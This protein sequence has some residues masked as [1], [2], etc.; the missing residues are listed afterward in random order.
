MR[1]PSIKSLASLRLQR[2][3]IAQG[4]G[5]ARLSKVTPTQ[6]SAISR[7]L[8]ETLI[9]SNAPQSVASDIINDITTHLTDKDKCQTS[10]M[11]DENL[12]G[13]FFHYINSE[14]PLTD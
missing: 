6:T 10:T 9:A 3:K 4:N 14:N 2:I 1:N 13:E 11:I 8:K 12:S 5:S 7:S